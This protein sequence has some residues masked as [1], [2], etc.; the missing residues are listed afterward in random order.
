MVAV[1][2]GG[3]AVLVAG[4]LL[5]PHIETIREHRA[6]TGPFLLSVLVGGVYLIW[7]LG[8]DTMDR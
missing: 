6:I 1:M 7:R 8:R 2:V 3:M 4:H 5:Q